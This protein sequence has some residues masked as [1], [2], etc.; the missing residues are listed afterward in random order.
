MPSQP[1]L[2][3]MPPPIPLVK[4]KISGEFAISFLSEVDVPQL[5]ASRTITLTGE[6]VSVTHKATGTEIKWVVVREDD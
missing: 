5:G 1:E 2:D 6:C 3:K 4:Q